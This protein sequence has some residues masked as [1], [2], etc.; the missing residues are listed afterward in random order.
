M[1]CFGYLYLCSESCE[2]RTPLF[3]KCSTITDKKILSTER[4]GVSVLINYLELKDFA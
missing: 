4:G 1:W 3:I 2:T